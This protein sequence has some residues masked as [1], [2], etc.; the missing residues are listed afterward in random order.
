M[1]AKSNRN[2]IFQ[3]ESNDTVESH[4]ESLTFQMF[5]KN[6]IMFH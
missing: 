5:S 6:M 4:R 2:I 1:Q 3:E